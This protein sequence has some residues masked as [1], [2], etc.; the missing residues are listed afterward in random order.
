[1]LF[2]Q[3]LVFLAIFGIPC[4]I[5]I[6]PYILIMSAETLF[7]NKVTLADMGD[8]CASDLRIPFGEMQ[9]SPQLGFPGCSE[10]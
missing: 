2:S 5:D 6:P 1:M 10:N 7:L 4:L 9:F 8:V 3:L